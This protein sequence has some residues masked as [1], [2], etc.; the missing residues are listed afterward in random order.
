MINIFNKILS[1][2]AMT[3]CT[4]ALSKYFYED[5]VSDTCRGAV[6]AAWRG[7]FHFYFYILAFYFHLLAVSFT[8]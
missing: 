8:Y 3:V 2:A 5:G 7:K 6:A 4:S 1:I